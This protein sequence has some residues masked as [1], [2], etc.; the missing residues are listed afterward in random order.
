[1][2]ERV[3]LIEILTRLTADL[4]AAESHLSPRALSP[5]AKKGAFQ[6][7]TQ[8]HW[9]NQNKNRGLNNWPR[10]IVSFG[11]AYGCA[12]LRPSLLSRSSCASASG[13]TS[14]ACVS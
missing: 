13:N 1:M 9:M 3:D 7:A 5:R 4:P 10:S 6:T 12:G 8:G 14:S 11:L 2:V